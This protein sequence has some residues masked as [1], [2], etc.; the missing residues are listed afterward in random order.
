MYCI[1]IIIINI[2][3][4][5]KTKLNNNSQIRLLRRLVTTYISFGHTSLSLLIYK[6]KI[7]KTEQIIHNLTPN[8]NQR[9]LICKIKHTF[10]NN[11]ISN[12]K[13]N[14]HHIIVTYLGHYATVFYLKCNERQKSI[15]TTKTNKIRNTRN[16]VRCIIYAVIRDLKKDAICQE[17]VFK[18]LPLSM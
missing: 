13:L 5:N 1:K 6:Q 12:S 3:K 10:Q 2:L 18:I 14:Y 7:I 4:I 11:S 15:S 16:T 17:K 8:S 9:W